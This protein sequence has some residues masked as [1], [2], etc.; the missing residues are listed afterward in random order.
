MNQS[1]REIPKPTDAELEIMQV[2]WKYGP[3]TVRFVN[4]RLS[5]NKEVGYTT[6]LK[7][8]QIMHAKGMVGRELQGRTHIYKPALDEAE[9]QAKLLNRLLETAFGGSSKKM[10]MSLL[11]N[12]KASGTELEE[13]KK[14]IDKLESE[15]S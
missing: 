9:T 3:N 13:I 11:G 10:V 6:T 7:I 5:E 12:S 4:D 1:K 14:L 8:L 15:Q 2:L